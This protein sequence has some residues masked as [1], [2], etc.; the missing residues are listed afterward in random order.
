MH[1]LQVRIAIISAAFT[2]Q[3]V[4]S[5]IFTSPSK[6]RD[7]GP[8]LAVR[9]SEIQD[10]AQG[11][12]ANDRQSWDSNPGLSNPNTPRVHLPLPAPEGDSGGIQSGL[13]PGP[14]ELGFSPAS[15]DY[16]GG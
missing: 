6:A 9:E 14:Q 13:K 16:H 7:H 5:A 10:R 12:R 3:Q 4:I 8:H 1:T 11:H 15:G 2:Q